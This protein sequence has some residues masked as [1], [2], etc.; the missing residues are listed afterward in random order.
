[1][2]SISMMNAAVRRS[3]YTIA[4]GKGWHDQFIRRYSVSPERVTTIEN[5]TLLVDL[6][7]RE[8]LRAFAPQTQDTEINIVYLG[9]FY[10]W[11]G[12]EIL[13][14]AFTRLRQQGIQTRLTLIGAGVQ[15]DACKQLVHSSGLE[16]YVEFTGQLSAEQYAPCLASAH[17][18]V[19][20]YCGWKEFSGMKLFDYKAAGLAIAASGENGQP[21]TL[22]HGKTGWIVPPCGEDAL[23]ETLLM[24]S[25]DERLRRSLG[26][27]ARLDAEQHHSWD[28]TVE[29]IEQ[30]FSRL[31]QNRH[32]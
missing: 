23:F 13:L 32:A 8:Q 30:I 21:D 11:H 4:S 28:H 5:G 17:I 2:L 15:L 27:A 7:R 20:P 14:H 24:L 19:S 25:R 16:S 6:L 9:G 26:Q 12:V 1:M 22:I 3:D 10:P 29:Q 18:G 31:T